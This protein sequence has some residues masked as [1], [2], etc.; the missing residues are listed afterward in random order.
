MSNIEN[1]CGQ[2]PINFVKEDIGSDPNYVFINDPAYSTRQL[3]DADGSTVFVNSFVECEHY[4]AGGW[5]FT[6]ET[7]LELSLHNYLFIFAIAFIGIR[8]FLQKYKVI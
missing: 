1:I 6:P 3:F 4:V 7:N 5:G 2:Y 8:F